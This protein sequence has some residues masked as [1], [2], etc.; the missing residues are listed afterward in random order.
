[1]KSSDDNDLVMET[2]GRSSL[3]YETARPQEFENKGY[4]K[5]YGV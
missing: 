3:R 5:D 2:T 4:D 1:M